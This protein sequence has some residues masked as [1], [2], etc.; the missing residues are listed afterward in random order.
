MNYQTT[1]PERR[2]SETTAP[3]ISGVLQRACACGNHTLAGG[4]CE[5]CSGNKETAQLQ[6]AAANEEQAKEV[7]PIVNEVLHS[8]GQSLD[9]KARAFFEPR[10][11]YDFSQVRV[12]TDS[13]AADSAQAVKALAYTVGRD[14]VFGG[15]QYAPET[16]S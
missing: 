6:R 3:P 5:S 11:G 4:E 14:V 7:P 15:G 10:F 1:T 12:H 13:R 9:G 2:L 16:G 8:P